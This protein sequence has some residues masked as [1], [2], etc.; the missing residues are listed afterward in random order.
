M[1]NNLEIDGGTGHFLLNGVYSAWFPLYFLVHNLHQM[2]I[3][4]LNI[5]FI[6]FIGQFET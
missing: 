3:Y 1:R 4:D 2:A 5:V 6:T